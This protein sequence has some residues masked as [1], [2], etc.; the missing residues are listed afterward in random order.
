MDYK[1]FRSEKGSQREKAVCLLAL[2]LAGIV[3]VQCITAAVMWH[4]NRRYK[5]MYDEALETQLIMQ[6]EINTLRGG[7]T[8]GK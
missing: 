4:F 2:L 3:V 1:K 6:R 7:E 8:E 5:A